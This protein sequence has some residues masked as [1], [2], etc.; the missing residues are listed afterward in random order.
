MWGAGVGKRAGQ[1]PGRPAGDWAVGTAVLGNWSVCWV[2]RSA[3]SQA[4]PCGLGYGSCLSW[5]VSVHRQVTQAGMRQALEPCCLIVM[6][7][8]PQGGFTKSEVESL[9]SQLL[10]LRR[11]GRL[12]P[13]PGDEARCAGRGEEPPTLTG[14]VSPSRPCSKP[15]RQ[16]TAAPTPRASQAPF[17]WQ[18]LLPPLWDSAKV[19]DR[20]LNPRWSGRLLAPVLTPS[21]SLLLSISIQ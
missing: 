17:M 8:P 10:G 5:P 19:R 18:G 20:M 21:G 16:G 12:S 4:T 9:V 7:L 15:S 6:L 1:V 2:L 3:G 14:M 13:N 11:H